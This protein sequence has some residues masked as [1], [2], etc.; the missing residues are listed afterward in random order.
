MLLLF[1]A[2]IQLIRYLYGQ[3]EATSQINYRILYNVTDF[4]VEKHL[5]KPRKFGVPERKMLL[6]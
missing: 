5:F 4:C 1:W 2:V 6:H 3:R